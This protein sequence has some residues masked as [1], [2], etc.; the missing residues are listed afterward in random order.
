MPANSKYLTKSAWQKFAKISAGLVG[1]YII[2]VLFHM[3]LILL[4]P[5]HHEMLVTT[6]F[7]FVI[8]WGIM[9]L[10]PYLFTN[11]LKAWGLYIVIII[12]LYLLYF[13]ANKSNPFVQ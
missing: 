1:G 12:I 11:G 3:V 10:I 5:A 2:S 4:I 7:S 6:I 8:V 9:L 13:L